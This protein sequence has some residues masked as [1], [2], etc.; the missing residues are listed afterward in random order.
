[1]FGRSPADLSVFR[2]R[3]AVV[4]RL[5]GLDFR[6]LLRPGRARSRPGGLKTAAIL[7]ARFMALA[8]NCERHSVS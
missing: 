2:L 7:L 4:S 3:P 6:A 8:L 5:D 1:M